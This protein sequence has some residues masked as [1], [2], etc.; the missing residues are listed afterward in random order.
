[1]YQLC[2]NLFCFLLSC[3]CYLDAAVAGTSSHTLFIIYSQLYN[4]IR[5][6]RERK[7]TLAKEGLEFETIK[8]TTRMSARTLTAERVAQLNSIDFTWSI[9][10]PKIAWEDRYQEVIEYYNEYNKWPSQS[11]GGLGLWVHKVRFLT[12]GALYIKVMAHN[13]L[14]TIIHEATAEL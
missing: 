8:T 12:D 1:M 14:F 7:A 10:Q 2:N 4:W 3:V 13:K 5:V 9:L 6:V 11:M